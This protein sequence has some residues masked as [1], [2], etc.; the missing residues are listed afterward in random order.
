MTLSELA[1]NAESKHRIRR[2]LS[3]VRL[4]TGHMIAHGADS[5]DSVRHLAGRVGAIGR[6]A[7][8]PM[9]GGMDLELLVLDELLAQGVHRA[10]ALITG[11]EVRLNAK[12]AELMRLAIHELTTNA[13]KFGAMSESPSPL[14]VIWWIADPAS[15]RLHFEWAE[16]GVQVAAEARRNPGFGSHVVKRLIAS[17]LQGRG[18]MLF[19]AK[20]IMCIIE[21]PSCEGLL[22]NE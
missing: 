1:D 13:I 4:I 2:L 22:K 19:L 15:S 17:E 18:D 21:I 9:A 8:A 10:P 3:M 14:R 11:P 12:S 5:E 20:G 6:A 16:D 7:V